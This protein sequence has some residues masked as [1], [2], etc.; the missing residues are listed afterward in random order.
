MK[1]L[2]ITFIVL[3][4]TVKAIANDFNFLGA[5]SYS[6]QDVPYEYAAGTIYINDNNENSDIEIKVK[7][8]YNE[9]EGQS[10]NIEEDQI[11]FQIYVE[12]QDV[13]VTLKFS[14]NELSGTASTV[15]GAF[16]ISGNRIE[17]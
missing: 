5:W 8:R 6:A 3:L 12:G 10:I 16:A 17:E 2:N 7:T 4:L 11:S 1:T 15:D 9:Y 14:D 13:T